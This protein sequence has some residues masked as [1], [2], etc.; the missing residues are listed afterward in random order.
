M[1]DQQNNAVW[2]N[3]AN[4]EANNALSQAKLQAQIQKYIQAHPIMLAHERNSSFWDYASLILYDFP[5]VSCI[6]PSRD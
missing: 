1:A 6:Q 4:N 3:G 2:P 5:L